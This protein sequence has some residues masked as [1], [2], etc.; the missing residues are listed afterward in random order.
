MVQE[1]R[2]L[3]GKTVAVTR[4]REQAEETVKAIEA[5]GGKAYL[6]PTIEIRGTSDLS[7]VKAFLDALSS[8]K[9]DYV[10]FMSANG[11]KH[12]LDNVKGLD[13]E[14]DLRKSLKNTLVIAVGPKTA[15]ELEKKGFNVDLIPDRYTSDGILQCLQQRHVKGKTVYIPR[16]SEA[17]P[18]LAEKLRK[19]GN[20]VEEIYVYQ[21]QLPE[22]G[23]LA[24]RFVRDLANKK[25][26]AIIFSSSLG[27][28]NFFEMLTEVVS[29]EKLPNLMNTKTVVVAI[30]PTTART[31]TETGIKVVVM[32]NKHVLEEALDALVN[33]WKTSRT[34]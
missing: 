25:I 6:F 5:L 30:G 15:Q 33:Y 28:K 34:S 1:D 4:P 13:A 26:D 31:I 17:P 27:V 21:S 24:E 14:K 12:L 3:T 22:D 32:P 20:Q 29:K 11:V 23:G 8:K 7:A 9:V 19:M 18:E 2:P 16:T 10:I